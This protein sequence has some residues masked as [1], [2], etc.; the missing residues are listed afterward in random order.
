MA[1]LQYE[2]GMSGKLYDFILIKMKSKLR[3]YRNKRKAIYQQ[4]HEIVILM[5]RSCDKVILIHWAVKK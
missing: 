3:E 4:G 5:T 2:E 1:Y